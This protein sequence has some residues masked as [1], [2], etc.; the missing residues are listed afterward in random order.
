MA[1]TQTM[2]QLTDDL[3]ERLDQNAS[4]KGVSRSQLIREAVEAYLADDVEA[5]IDRRI[6]AAYTRMPQGDEFDH[7]EWGDLGRMVDALTVDM[8]R[9]LDREE[10]E[11][12]LEPW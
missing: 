5:E 12:G 8:L 1:R 2:V 11:A 7:D 4:R 6:V 9:A 3:L 10:R